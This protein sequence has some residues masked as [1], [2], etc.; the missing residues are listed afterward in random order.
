M[1]TLAAFGIIHISQTRKEIAA[2]GQRLMKY[3]KY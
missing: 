2:E 1:N 3:G